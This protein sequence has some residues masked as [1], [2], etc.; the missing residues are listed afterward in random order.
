MEIVQGDANK[1][2]SK[3]KSS[4]IDLVLTDP[5]YKDYISNRVVEKQKKIVKAKFSFKDLVDSI[6]RVL[7]NDRHFYIWCD[8][9]TYAEA[10]DAIDKSKTLKF[11]N[12]IVWI[13]NNHGAGDLFSGFAPQHEI[14][15][16][17]YKGKGRKFQANTVRMSD[18]LFKKD[19]KGNLSFYSKVNPKIGGHPTIKPI[20]I[21]KE[22][23][24]R[25]SK[26]GEVVL[27][28][29]AGSFS[30]MKASLE[31][32]RKSIGFELDKSYVSKA[33]TWLKNE[34]KKKNL[35]TK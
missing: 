18:V 30:T 5:P 35:K 25:S 1:L 31:C 28:P 24:L 6:E 27:D 22:F 7:K 21:L 4:S 12:M 20:D 2:M 19:D 26:R 34:N 17:G 8:H 33:K 16:Y 9:L 11:K 32:G 14:C 23:I 15:I 10:F 3:L 29:Y 13:K